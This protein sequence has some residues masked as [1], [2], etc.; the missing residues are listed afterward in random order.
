MIEIESVSHSI[1]KTPI[2]RDISATIPKGCLTALI[3]PNGAGKSTLLSLVARLETLQTGR[4]RVDGL[5][6]G[7]TP[8]GKLARHLAIQRQDTTIATR[9]TVRQLVGF[10]RYPH[11]R[12][13]PGRADREKIEAAIGALN[14]GPLAHRFLDTL[15]GGQ[16]QRALIAMSVAQ[17][18][19]YLLLDEPL[20]NLDM[21]HARGLM[22][23]L[24][25]LAAR[26]GRTVLVVLHEVNYAAAHADHIVAMK[27]GRIAGQGPPE[28]QLT[29][30]TIE[31]VF[32]T[33]VT[34][35]RSAG[36]PVVHHFG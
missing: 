29:A 30:E 3:G 15:S 18:T 9:L 8:T 33:P 5:D 32:E 28:T 10:G 36:R 14:L 20:N 13:R 23:F 2:L 19:D 6:V 4:I 26:H 35:T 34:I 12:G 24:R 31:R 27:D 16:R 11:S 21:A 1:G 7:T 17:E 25:D 22:E